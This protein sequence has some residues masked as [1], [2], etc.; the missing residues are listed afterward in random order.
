MLM[1]RKLFT[2]IVQ[3]KQI[4]YLSFFIN[5]KIAT[6]KYKLKNKLFKSNIFNN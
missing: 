4:I 2:L 1:N 3:L 6:Q 5:I